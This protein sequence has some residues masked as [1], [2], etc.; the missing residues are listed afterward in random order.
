MVRGSEGGGGI[1]WEKW[2]E[3]SVGEC[4]VKDTIAIVKNI[5]IISSL[6]KLWYTACIIAH[7]LPAIGMLTVSWTISKIYSNVTTIII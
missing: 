6:K 3:S 5:L 7:Y 4:L 1:K 2:V